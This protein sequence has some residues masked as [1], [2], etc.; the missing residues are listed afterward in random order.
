MKI[1]LAYDLKQEVSATAAA[2]DDALEEYD[3]AETINLLSVAIESAGHQTVRLGGGRQ[4]LNNIL[5]TNVDFVF[6][7][8]E[9]RG[10]YRGREAQVP[11]V[12]E[13]LGIPYSGADPQTLA[14]ALDKPLTK[15]L[16]RSV[17]ITTPKW[18][19]FKSADDLRDLDWA[20]FRFPAFI[21][22]AFEGS[23][24]GIRLT[25]MANSPDEVAELVTTLLYSYGQA[26][27]AEEFIDGDEVTCG[28]IGN[29]AVDAAEPL[30]LPMRIVP[31]QKSGHF[32]YSLEIKRDYKQLVDYEYPARLSPKI[33]SGIKDQART[34]FTTL[35]CRDFSRIDFRIA[36]DGTPYFL[37]IN[38]LPGLSVDSDLYI[39][40][41]QM[42]WSHD[43]LIKTVL[44]GAMARYPQ[45]C[46]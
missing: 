33:I 30:V 2:P 12:L 15:Q 21:K 5:E 31:R 45:L 19:V 40:V 35:G 10:N 9:G 7:I 24:K 26:V 43:R 20:G 14:I 36:T 8:S 25:S 38:P 29:F 28:I 27:M 6:N 34:I 3:S 1:G 46:R 13:M 18:H 17:G 4:F 42:G 16:L 39:L 37:E 23:S 44:A 32:I 11:A 22:P 41:T